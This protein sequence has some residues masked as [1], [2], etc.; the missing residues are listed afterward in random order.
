MAVL[1]ANLTL[2]NFGEIGESRNRLYGIHV[3]SVTTKLIGL[4]RINYSLN[5]TQTYET[6]DCDSLSKTS[7]EDIGE[8]EIRFPGCN[9]TDLQLTCSPPAPLP[10]PSI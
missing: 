3:Q 4:Y 1:S 5:F 10:F 6:Y 8:P 9:L 2:G 7:A